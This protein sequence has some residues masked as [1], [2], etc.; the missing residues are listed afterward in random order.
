MIQLLFIG[1]IYRLFNKM[2]RTILVKNNKYS[3]FNNILDKKTN[4][5]M[6]IYI[7]K[8]IYSTYIFSLQLN[9]YT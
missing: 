4:I 8:Y 7:H 5:C 3:D 6:I 1:I 2:S 9:Q